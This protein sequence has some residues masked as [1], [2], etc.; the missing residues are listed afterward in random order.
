MIETMR[1]PTCKHFT[2]HKSLRFV[3]GINWW[4]CTACGGEHWRRGGIL[5]ILKK[6]AAVLLVVLAGCADGGDSPPPPFQAPPPQ[7]QPPFAIALAGDQMVLVGDRVDVAIQT[8]GQLSDGRFLCEGIAK[9]PGSQAVLHGETGLA[10]FVPDLPGTYLVRAGECGQGELQDP[11]RWAPADTAAI[12]AIAPAVVAKPAAA[13]PLEAVTITGQLGTGGALSGTASYDP[14]QWASDVGFAGNA[15]YA[16]TAYR[17]AVAP[18]LPQLPAEIVFAAGTATRCVGVC[19]FNFNAPVTLYAFEQDGRRLTLAFDARGQ[20]LPDQS[21]LQWDQHGAFY[22][23]FV[24]I[25][26]AAVA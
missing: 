23:T 10:W 5:G 14:N 19:L 6:T 11:A 17:I 1:C 24:F 21:R 4:R 13:S 7:A 8:S 22:D 3:K 12:V 18:R 20:F 26:A 25:H 9:P 16:I 2:L 15:V